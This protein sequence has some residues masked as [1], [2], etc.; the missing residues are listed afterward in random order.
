MSRNTDLAAVIGQH[1]R[2]LSFSAPRVT[3][4]QSRG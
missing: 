4:A 1:T 3:A 2:E